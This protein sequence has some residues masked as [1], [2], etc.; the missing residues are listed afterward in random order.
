MNLK[1]IAACLVFTA[2]L[3]GCNYPGY[4]KKP[5][6]TV[7]AS[8]SPIVSRIADTQTPLPVTVTQTANVQTS[9][10]TPDVSAT[11]LPASATAQPESGVPMAALAVGKPV[12][13][14]VIRMVDLNQGWG[15]ARQD[16]KIDH[17]VRTE[18]GGSSWKDVSP[19]QLLDP[20]IGDA[21][22]V[23]TAFIDDQHAWAVYT[24]VDGFPPADVIVWQTADG[25]S[26]WTRSPALKLSGM[27]G[28]F[29]PGFFA[30]SGKEHGW[31]LV[32]VDAGMNHD[33]SN[34]Y[35]SND[36]GTTW[37]LIT[38]PQSENIDSL[39]S[40]RI[41]GLA[42]AD[43][44]WGWAL[45]DTN[46][47][48]PGAFLVQ[49]LDGGYTW[50]DIDLPAPKDLDWAHEIL[51]C[52]THAPVF[53][54]ESTGYLLVTCR[55][56][57]DHTYTYFYATTDKG[58]SWRYTK[59]IRNVQYLV[60]QDEMHGLALGRDVLRTSDGGKTWT[61][62]KHMKW[63]GTFSFVNENTGWAV[64]REAKQIALVHTTDG[65]K[66]WKLLKPVVEK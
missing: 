17:V 20:D 54:A 52:K 23:V 58:S 16:D 53:P 65:G 38:D 18:D 10:T 64:A 44:Q 9:P 31:L 48:R 28:F 45:K 25:G 11:P 56:T 59:L 27:E 12:Y 24:P 43:E 66:T 62:V 32:H 5:Q 6:A 37:Q 61:L 8:V 15:V 26:H 47:V 7:S 49:T 30:F 42:F 22:K 13:L 51:A 57:A 3:A 2:V 21:W 4:S 35:A 39:M 46:G 33:Y 60:F 40:L 50:K 29:E 55:D 1:R 63:E 34:L 14:S 41:V 36:G 19:P